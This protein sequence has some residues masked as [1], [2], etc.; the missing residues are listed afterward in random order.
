MTTIFVFSTQYNSFFNTVNFVE[1][2]IEG[3]LNGPGDSMLVVLALALLLPLLPPFLLLLLYRYV[4]KECFNT[5]G[6]GG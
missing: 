2:W 4:C 1:G 6:G 3:M 5:E